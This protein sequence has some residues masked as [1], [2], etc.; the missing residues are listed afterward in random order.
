MPGEAGLRWSELLSVEEVFDLMVAVLLSFRG[1]RRRGDGVLREPFRI[2]ASCCCRASTPISLP[3]AGW[4]R[5][6][7]VGD[8]FSLAGRVSCSG[9]LIS[10]AGV[11]SVAGGCCFGRCCSFTA[12]AVLRDAEH[13]MLCSHLLPQHTPAT[14]EADNQTGALL[15]VCFVVDS[16]LLCQGSSQRSR[17]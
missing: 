6:I 13:P 2:P 17:C 15:S 4:S 1:G 11:F 8:A 12:T 3:S 9:A 14:A 16:C 5:A 7:G 10:S